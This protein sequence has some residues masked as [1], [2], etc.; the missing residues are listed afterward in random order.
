MNFIFKILLFPV[1]IVYGTVIWIRNLLYDSKI[2]KSKSF[3]FPVISVGNLTVGGTG[4]TP[5]VEYLIRYLSKDYGVATLSRGYR[6]KT[7]GFLLAD[8]NS[9][10]K[11]IGDE[12]KQIKEK[13]PL[14]QVAVCE[15]RKEGIKRL[16]EKRDSELIILDDAY[17]HRKV[18][19]GLSILLMNFYQLPM[20]DCL[21]PAGRLREHFYQ[22]KR[23]DI[24]IVTKCPENISDKTVH[25]LKKKINPSE[26]QSLY[27]T[28]VKYD[29]IAPVFNSNRISLENIDGILLIS[30]IAKS[31]P[32]VKHIK[33]KYNHVKH[34]SFPDHHFYSNADIQKIKN[35]F[36]RLKAKTKIILT[37]EKDAI[38]FKDI[39]NNKALSELSDFFYSIPIKIEFLH[40]QNIDF[41]EKINQFIK[42]YRQ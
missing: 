3:N 15:N 31:Q 38:R 13:F 21:L 29:K 6:R 27:F 24:I 11:D 17:Q 40:D 20:H 7:K 4:K 28:T 34:L 26:N 25:K 18:K 16:I 32:L 37:T 8:N 41:E 12:A 1:S 14:I 5:H 30:G 36:D 19:A 9:G 22:K 23:A 39:V 42:T 2:W 35:E 10:A 33:L